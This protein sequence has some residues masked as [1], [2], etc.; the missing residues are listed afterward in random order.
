[1]LICG[2]NDELQIFCVFFIEEGSLENE[3]IKINGFLL[4]YINIRKTTKKR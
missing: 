3:K 2:F 4:D 1:M